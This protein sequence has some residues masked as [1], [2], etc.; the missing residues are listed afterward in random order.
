[1]KESICLQQNLT[2]KKSLLTLLDINIK[3]QLCGINKV[4]FFV[5]N[6]TPSI[7]NVEYTI[8]MYTP[9]AYSTKDPIYLTL[10]PSPSTS[11]ESQFLFDNFTFFISFVFFFF[12]LI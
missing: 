2:Q 5:I 8:F 12:S 7:I 11:R 6:L 3:E 10:F 1:M 9:C 4:D